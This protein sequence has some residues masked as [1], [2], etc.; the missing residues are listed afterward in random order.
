MTRRC[1]NRCCGAWV[2][3][4]VAVGKRWGGRGTL[5]FLCRR[6]DDGRLLDGLLLR[7]WS[8]D[9]RLVAAAS[10]DV[11][12]SPA[13]REERGDGEKGK[14]EFHGSNGLGRWLGEFYSVGFPTYE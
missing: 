10:G 13:G 5:L 4:S 3:G 12:V 2:M 14:L 1:V 7:G 9:G 8:D 11:D 6:S